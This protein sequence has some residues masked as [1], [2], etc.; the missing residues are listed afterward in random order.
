[1]D[2]CTHPITDSCTALVGKETLGHK[3]S[4]KSGYGSSTHSSG[5]KTLGSTGNSSSE[6]K[7]QYRSC[8]K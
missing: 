8:Q 3:P 2:L 7:L 6:I 5:T 1:M 4:S